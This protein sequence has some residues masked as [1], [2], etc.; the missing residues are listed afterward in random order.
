MKRSAISSWIRQARYRAKRY[1]IYND[2]QIEDIEEIM[3]L[4]DTCC[5]Y[6]GVP[7]DTFDHPFPL[8]ENTVN[9]QSNVL[10][11][12][13]HC[14]SIKKNH[15]LIWMFTEGYI[16]EK[17]YLSILQKMFSRKNSGKIKEHVKKLAGL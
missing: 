2:L 8:N 4:Y 10:P 15:D 12:C 9:T 1:N 14:K 16:K 11:S 5:A 17:T 13:K 7:A 3:L 6:C